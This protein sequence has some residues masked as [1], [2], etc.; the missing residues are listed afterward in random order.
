LTRMIYFLKVNQGGSIGI[1]IQSKW[2]EPLRNTT[3]DFLAA[4]RA[5]SFE[6]GW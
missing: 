5:L 1:V 3:F 2:Y 4:Q 6:V